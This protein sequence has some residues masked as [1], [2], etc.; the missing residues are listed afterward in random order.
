MLSRKEIKE[1]AAIHGDG[2]IFVSLYLNVNPL[3]NPKGDYIIHF[4]N[5]TISMD[6]GKFLYLLTA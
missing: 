6:C 4:K 2:N 1:L 3:T 5:I